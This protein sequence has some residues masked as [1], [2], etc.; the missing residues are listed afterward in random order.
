MREKDSKERESRGV[1]C[2][3]KWF[4]KN[5]FVNR[6]PNFCEGFSDQLETIFVDFYFAVKQTP[7]NDE[8]ILR[9]MFYIKTNR[10]LDHLAS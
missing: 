5:F 9:K 1:K 3:E 8:N 6:F 4:T 7:A 10:A 2:F